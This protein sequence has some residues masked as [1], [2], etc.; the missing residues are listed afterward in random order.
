MEGGPTVSGALPQGGLRPFPAI[1]RAAAGRPGCPRGS[2]VFSKLH[3]ALC[4][5]PGRLQAACGELGLALG[6]RGAAA[7]E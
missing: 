1:P 4:V 3:R 6:S 7:G 2:L 5:A